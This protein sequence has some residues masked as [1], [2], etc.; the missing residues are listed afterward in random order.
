MADEKQNELTPEEMREL[1]EFLEEYAPLTPEQAREVIERCGGSKKMTLD[2]YE[3]VLRVGRFDLAADLIADV[4][5]RS[6]SPNPE[7]AKIFTDI[8]ASMKHKSS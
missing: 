3:A 4:T 7:V 1:L 6:Q 5:A 8:L 2:L